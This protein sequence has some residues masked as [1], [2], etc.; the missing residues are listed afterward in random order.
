MNTA[1]VTLC[2]LTLS[3]A[4]AFAGIDPSPV[5]KNPV[6]PPP[7]DPCAG[8]ISYSNV[9]LLYEHTDFDAGN[10]DSGNGAV[11]RYEYEAMKQFYITVDADYDSYEFTDRFVTGQDGR[12]VDIE[13]WTVSLGIG[14]HI[15]LT[16][17]I[18]LA[19]DAGITYTDVSG[20]FGGAVVTNGRFDDSETGWFI[21]PHIRAKWGCLTVHAGGAYHDYGGDY[22]EWS[23][24]GRLYYQITQQLD[25]TAGIS[26][27]DEA[28]VYSAGVRW[29]F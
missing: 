26:S 11:L 8:P 2:G 9:E 27:G 1:Y 29:R 7:A 25:L 5:D 19:G 21:R 18:H 20:D 16:D 3:A 24:Y 14:G 4:C 15:A 23:A 12:V 17:N 6:T 28:D 10:V 13:Q 22:D